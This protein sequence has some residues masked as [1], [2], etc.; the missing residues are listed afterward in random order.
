MLLTG[1]GTSVD[2]LRLV[3]RNDGIGLLLPRGR[4]VA[5]QL[6]DALT[7]LKPMVT[8]PATWSN[9]TLYVLRTVTFVSAVSAHALIVP[10]CQALLKTGIHNL[11]RVVGL[12]L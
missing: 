10:S 12:C 4:S 5:S 7:A 3:E 11:R 6:P 9:V 2:V 8:V 1:I